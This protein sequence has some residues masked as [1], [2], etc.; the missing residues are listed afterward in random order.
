MKKPSSHMSM[1]A[2]VGR[3]MA[4]GWQGTPRISGDTAGSCF[5]TGEFVKETLGGGGTTV[6]R[7]LARFF[8][9]QRPSGQG[10]GHRVSSLLPPRDLSSFL[11]RMG[12][13]IPAFQLFMCSR[14]P[15]VNYDARKN[16]HEHEYAVGEI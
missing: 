4:S 9:P 8:F 15:L 14:F 16:P 10:H 5:K 7:L 11:S 6:E 13:S 3:T 1:F 2:K 12:F